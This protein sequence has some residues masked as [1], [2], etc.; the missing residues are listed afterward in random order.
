MKYYFRP[1]HS[2]A[3]ERGFVSACD[4]DTEETQD[5]TLALNANIMA[6]RFYENVGAFTDGTPVNSRK[7]HRNY[8]K[9]HN[10]THMGD[11]EKTW[12]KAAEERAEHK[13]G[14]TAREIKERREDLARAIYH[15][16][17]P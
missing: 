11:F 15:T 6:G 3:N 8:L 12:A 14:G 7:D 16:R 13:K 9:A 2:K 10:V 5:P 4:L 17:R 1:T